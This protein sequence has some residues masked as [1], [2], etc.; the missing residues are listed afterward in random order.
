[1]GEVINALI[2]AIMSNQVKI[3]VLEPVLRLMSQLLLGAL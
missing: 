2:A 3:P 1:M